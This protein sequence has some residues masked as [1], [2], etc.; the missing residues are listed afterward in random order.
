MAQSVTAQSYSSHD[1]TIDMAAPPPLAAMNPQQPPRV[2][3]TTAPA[4][5]AVVPSQGPMAGL[6]HLHSTTVEHG[7]T[8]HPVG[9]TTTA[10]FGPILEQLQPFPPLP[11][12][13]THAPTHTSNETLARGEERRIN[14]RADRQFGG[15]QA[16]QAGVSR[17]GNAQ[18][19]DQLSDMSQASA[20]HTQSRRSFP[21][22]LNLRTNVGDRLGPRPD[23]HAR[24][25]QHEDVHE[26][27]GSQGG[28][29][30]GHRDEDR[31]ERR[32]AARSQRN[33]H[34]RIGPQ[35]GQLDNHHNEDREERRSGTRSRRTNSRRQTTGNPLQAQSTNT[36]PRQ[37][38]REGRPTQANEELNQHHLTM[39]AE[40][41]EK[42]V[43]N[44]LRDLK[45]GGNF[46]DTL[47]LR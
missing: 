35:G 30:D 47:R 46:E 28:Q 21:S 33:I 39:R 23:I 17:Q 36:P 5:A 16:G 29:L 3:G 2:T 10:D 38:N 11:P 9:L 32:S 24:L 7:G 25:G 26:R 44:R 19:R 37:R 34:E 18:Q 31:E 20:S 12:R 13:S 8:S 42:L 15:N 14:E 4:S 45:I 1:P 40:D 27:L 6:S 41:V 22:R 43:N